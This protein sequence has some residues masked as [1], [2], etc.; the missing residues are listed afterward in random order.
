MASQTPAGEHD[1]GGDLWSLLQARGFIQQCTDGEKVRSELRSG[2]VTAYVGMDPTADS[3]HVGHLLPLMALAHLQRA[4][5]RP[6][7]LMGGGTAMIGDPSGKTEMRPMLSRQEIEQNV[8]AIRAQVEHILQTAASSPA[9]SAPTSPS[10]N[11]SPPAS[12]T[13]LVLNNADWILPL[14]YIDFLRE[15]GSQFSVNRMLAAECFRT[16]LERG[17]SFIEFN[18]MLLQA[19]DF[20]TLY[21]RY[22]CR[23]QMGGDDQW[24]NIIAGVELIRRLEG[25]QAYGLTFPLLVTSSGKK[26]GKTEA[27]AVWLSPAKTTPYEFYQFWR[28]T[29]DA[30]VAR[31]LALYTFLPLEEIRELTATSGAGLNRAKE[32][33]A[34]EV[35]ALVH[36]REQAEQ[37]QAAARL[38]FGGAIAGSMP[39]HGVAMRAAGVAAGAVPAVELSAAEVERG[40]AVVELLVRCGLAPSKSEGRRLIQQGGVE[41]NDTPI[42]DVERRLDM[43][44]FRGDDRQLLVRKGK[45]GFCWVR[46]H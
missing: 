41:I 38:L 23:L 30:D 19:Y 16:R 37:A 18:Y 3:L 39:P 27:G 2:P 15:V 26:M 20:L 9:D 31:F 34:Y 45:K 25:G 8:A 44:D 7:A 24:S 32:R 33:L 13:A 4:G 35:T 1:A 28:N 22:G 42:T 17:L 6:I 5:H 14:Q 12:S 46:L 43:A 21:R 40:I 10:A 36:G 29:A 11:S